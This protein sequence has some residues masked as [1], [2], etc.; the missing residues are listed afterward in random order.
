LATN[1]WK[2][3]P[4]HMGLFSRDDLIA[5]LTRIGQLAAEDAQVVELLVVGGGVMVLEFGARQSTKDLDGVVI[6]TTAPSKVREYAAKVAREKSW[7]LDWLNDG[8]KGFLTGA[9]TPHFLFQS[10]GIK[11]WRPAFEQLLAMKLCAWR[12][13]VDISDAQTLLLALPGNREQVWKMVELHLQPGKELK[14]RYAF[15]DL[16]ETRP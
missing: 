8:A 4:L 16:W 2:S 10:A 13:D 15:D 1:E 5:A 6:G 9:S 7:P 12:D 3:Y 14:A 11:V